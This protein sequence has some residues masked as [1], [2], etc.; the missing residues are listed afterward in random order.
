MCDSLNLLLCHP[1]AEMGM[2][3]ASPNLNSWTEDLG[4]RGQARG[5][6]ENER[7]EEG[8]EAELKLYAYNVMWKQYEDSTPGEDLPPASE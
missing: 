3:A 4:G 7:E 8:D 1:A 6:G 5:L 2:L